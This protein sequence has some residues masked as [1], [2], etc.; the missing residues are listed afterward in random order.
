MC[1]KR[2]KAMTTPMKQK[3]S[4]DRISLR[5]TSLLLE[6]QIP[7]PIQPDTDP[8]MK[9]FRQFYSRI[10]L[11]IKS[12]VYKKMRYLYKKFRVDSPYY[13]IFFD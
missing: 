10:E 3:L 7:D 8:K 11:F 2:E 4:N 9:V 6:S 5:F 12:L 13:P 1:L